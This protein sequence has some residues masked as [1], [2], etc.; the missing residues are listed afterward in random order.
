MSAPRRSTKRSPIEVGTR[1]G[2]DRFADRIVETSDQKLDDALAQT[3]P[4]SDPLAQTQAIVHV[5]VKAADPVR[6]DVHRR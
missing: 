6:H 5:G 4:A 1:G 3:F 2:G